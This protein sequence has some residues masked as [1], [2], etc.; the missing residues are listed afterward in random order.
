MGSSSSWAKHHMRENRNNQR[1]PE[2]FDFY[3]DL[4]VAEPSH[5][6]LQEYT[7]I[8]G[9]ENGINMTAVV[10]IADTTSKVVYRLN[11]L[12]HR[13]TVQEEKDWEQ[14]LYLEKLG[15]KVIDINDY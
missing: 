10:D 15:W 11:G 3:K 12:I 1:R 2:Q 7:I 14:K 4:R 8:Y 9:N 5:T 6:I 13:G